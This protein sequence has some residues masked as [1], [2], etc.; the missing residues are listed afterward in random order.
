MSLGKKNLR[1]DKNVRK[2]SPTAIRAQ[3]KFT[4]KVMVLSVIFTIGAGWWKVVKD[5]F[6]KGGHR[7]I[8]HRL[9]L[10]S[11]REWFPDNNCTFMHDGTTC[12][13]TKRVKAHYNYHGIRVLDLP[14]KAIFKSYRIFLERLEN[15]AKPSITY[16]QNGGNWTIDKN[17]A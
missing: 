16:Q 11:F 4:T 6:N 2:T 1:A 5:D 10:P 13:T 17:I 12:H 8:I 3:V 15:R 7:D 9:F 14:R